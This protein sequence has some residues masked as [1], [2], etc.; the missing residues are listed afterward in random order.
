MFRC[1]SKMFG[2]R[3]KILSGLKTWLHDP[4]QLTFFSACAAVQGGAEHPAV[5][6]GAGPAHVRRHAGRG[7]AAHLLGLLGGGRE[8]GATA[9]VARHVHGGVRQAQHPPP[10]ADVRGRL[11][12]SRHPRRQPRQMSPVRGGTL[13][14]GHPRG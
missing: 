6:Q 14:P 12:A 8:R 9:P 10:V 5:L 2:I 13:P 7:P 4:T 3:K 1:Y 11:A